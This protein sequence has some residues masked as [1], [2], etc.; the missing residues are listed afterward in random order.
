[1]KINDLVDRR[2][3]DAH[4]GSVVLSRLGCRFPHSFVQ[5]TDLSEQGLNLV[6]T[7]AT[8]QLDAISG[9]LLQSSLQ[10]AALRF[11]DDVGPQ[12]S[13]TECICF[14]PQLYLPDQ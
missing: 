13:G 9:V 2:Q 8:Q 6:A 10:L 4:Q 3:Y 5:T 11:G 12:V 7:F 1:M 14:L